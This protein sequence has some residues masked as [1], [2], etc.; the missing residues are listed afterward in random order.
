MPFQTAGPEGRPD[1]SSVHRPVPEALAGGGERTRGSDCADALIR[2][3]FRTAQ[4][5]TLSVHPPRRPDR[6]DVEAFLE[7]AYR[8]AFHGM[9][10]NHYP[11]LVSLR[12]EQGSI[13]AAAG[14]RFADSGGLYLEQYLDH[15]IELAFA[16]HFGVV[17]RS[18]IAEVGNLA[19]REPA[20]SLRLFLALA[21]RLHLSGATHVVATATRPLRRTF[22]RLGLDPIPLTRADPARLADG[23]ADWGAYYQREP[24]VLAGAIAPCLPRLVGAVGEA[25]L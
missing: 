14:F 22:S 8:H 3:I 19:A 21:R 23:G 13:R 15:P 18:R 4:P 16:A 24:E 11:Y 2:R 20:A 1:F 10:R 17:S 12:D 9:I 5:S 6:A 7:S 25:P